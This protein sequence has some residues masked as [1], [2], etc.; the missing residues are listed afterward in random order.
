[1]RHLLDVVVPTILGVLLAAAVFPNSG[2]GQVLR[3]VGLFA[4]S[5]PILTHPSTSGFMARPSNYKA[6]QCLDTQ[7][8]T[9]AEKQPCVHGTIEW[10]NCRPGLLWRTITS[11][12]LE[13]VMIK[14]TRHYCQFLCGASLSFPFRVA[15][16]AYAISAMP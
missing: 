10:R 11:M 7:A 16:Y 5:F 2:D 14:Y 3:S 8:E 1:M 12:V 13:F 15:S 6:A 9:Q 4:P